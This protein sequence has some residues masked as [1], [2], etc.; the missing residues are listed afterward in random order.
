MPNDL[1]ITT[2]R[3]GIPSGNTT[4]APEYKRQESVH[5]GSTPDYQTGF[6]QYAQASNWMSNIGSQVAAT[7]SNALAKQIGGEMGKTPHGELFPSFTN[8]DKQVAESYS[9]QAQATL[10]LQADELITKANI[11]AAKASRMT[12]ELIAKS[13][14]QISVGLQQIYSQAPNNIRPGLE[15]TYGAYQ[16]SQGASLTGR[17]INEQHEDRRNNT[18]LANDKNAEIAHTL[19]ASGHYDQAI[20]LA[21]STSAINKSAVEANIGLTPLQAKVATDTV[22]K[23]A[24]SGRLQNEYDQAVSSNK[25]DAYLKDVSKK[26]DWIPEAD[27]ADSMHNLLSYVN[28][29]Q[30]LKSQDEALKSQEMY[31]RI[32]TNPNIPGSEWAA[33]ESSVSPLAAAKMDFHRIQALKHQAQEGIGVDELIRNYGSGEAQAQA[34]E[35]IKNAA[36]YKNVSGTMQNNPNMTQDSAEVQVAMSSGAPVPV[37]IKT[38]NN[39][40]TSANPSQIVSAID[41]ISQLRD[42][43]AG[44]ALIGL[45][46]QADAIAT[47]FESKRG[48]MSDPDL[49][50]QV[51]D[52]ILNIPKDMQAT[53]NNSWNMMLAKKGAGGMGASTSLAHFALNEVHL[54]KDNFGGSETFATIYGNDIYQVLKSNFDVTRGDYQAAKAMT[55]RYVDQNYGETRVNGDRQFTDKPIEKALGYKDYDAVPYIQQNL[56]DKLNERFE[57]NKN[58]Q[59]RWEV[60]PIENQS[61]TSIFRK[62]FKPLEVIRHV[63]TSNGEKTF[64]YPVNLVGKPGNSWDI[65]LTTP[66]GPRNILLVAPHQDIISYTPDKEAI[67]KAYMAGQHGR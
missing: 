55:Q 43:E 34:P 53:L 62:T 61:S 21:K 66:D 14:H 47:Q 46:S 29:Q 48:S 6:D 18:I 50:R 45:S 35:K 51:T 27:Y 60:K 58:D 64:S 65:M 2:G 17:M 16:L 41:Q 23:S 28:T 15:K 3:G 26:P 4:S 7:A 67:D 40:L 32:A 54:N 13:Q 33:F 30:S 5:A 37:F 49:A 56:A 38:L 57:K 9:T 36:F 24:I 31:N 39:K 52:N 20:A 8:F 63:K 1:N 10:G 22:R 25:G 44:H 19:A 11:E 59:E 42:A 12:P